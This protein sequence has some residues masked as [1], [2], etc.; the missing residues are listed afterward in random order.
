M[1]LGRAGQGR[2]RPEH[3]Q[4]YRQQPGPLQAGLLRNMPTTRFPLIIRSGTHAPRGPGT[5]EI[6]AFRWA[7]GSNRAG[8]TERQKW[9]S[10]APVHLTS[11]AAARPIF[12]M[13]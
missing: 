7:N 5:S 13:L 3:Y 9:R 1:F 12:P 10:P 8:P 2:R 6:C 4:N 11:Q